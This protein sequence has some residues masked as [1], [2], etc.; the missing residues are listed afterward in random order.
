MYSYVYT[1]IYIYTYM[2]ICI[3][4]YIYK[5]ISC[6]QPN[7]IGVGQG[8]VRPRGTVRHPFQKAYAP[9]KF[10]AKSVSFTSA[11]SWSGERRGWI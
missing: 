11:L 1:R 10:P 6:T 4:V 5:Y 3:Y 7:F 2:Y 8:E 9:T